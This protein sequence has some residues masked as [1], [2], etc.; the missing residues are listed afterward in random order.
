M[1]VKQGNLITANATVMMTVAQ[2]QPAYVTFSVPA[3][4]F[5]AI[6]RHMAEKSL[7]VV[8]IPQDADKLPADGVLTFVDNIVDAT[9]DTIKL[10]ATFP[11][12]DRRLWPGQFAR[13][14]ACDSTPWKT[15]PWCRARPSR[16]ARTASSCSSST[17]TRQSRPVR[18]PSRS[19]WERIWSSRRGWKT[20][21]VV[22]TDGQLR[23]EKGTRVQQ[24]DADGGARG[25]RGRAGQPAAQAAPA[26]A[27]AR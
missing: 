11:N 2:V 25:G 17:R 23:L 6:R 26:P 5:P 13:A 1:T 14:S 20:G 15:R 8:A 27:T 4:H 7:S 24:T 3:V 21:D 16:P 19:A 10:K 12:T 9:T 22:V 18:S